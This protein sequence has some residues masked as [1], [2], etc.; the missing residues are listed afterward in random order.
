MPEQ[1]ADFRIPILIV[2]DDPLILNLL[3]TSVT[4][5]GYRCATARDGQEATELLARNEFSMV[6]TDM[7]MPRM[8]G[9]ALLKHVK[10]HYP[11]TDVIVVTRYT[12]TFSYTEVI[13]AG[14]CDFISKPFNIDELEAKISRV[15]REQK[16]IRKLEHLSMCD[17]LTDLYNRRCFDIK[18][19]EEVPRAHRQGYPVFLA[20][21]DVDG[22]KA[23]NDKYGHQAGDVALQA[24]G[25]G[26]VRCTR[27]NVDWSFR[28][29]GDEFAI[30]IPYASIDQVMR[31]AERILE[32]HRDH[33]PPETGLSIGLAQFV[34]HPGRSWDEDIE[35]LIRRADQALY[36]SK[37]ERGNRVVCDSS[38]PTAG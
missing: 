10:E 23:Y 25:H 27:E 7:T 24:I 34:R 3:E 21:L 37:K 28:Y 17:V 5:F 9:M 2:D 16:L 29:G 13:R 1:P 22:F 12:E 38:I 33:H 20:L 19:Q 36:Q 6:I 11:R 14:A 26:L 32:H 18:L 4:A 35:D 31:I 15:I 8:D 30:I